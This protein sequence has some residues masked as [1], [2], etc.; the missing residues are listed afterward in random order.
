MRF[1]EEKIKNIT[2]L[3]LNII[4]TNK[5]KKTFG[6]CIRLYKESNRKS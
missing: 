4:Y 3:T 6:V 1:K 2:F 5:K